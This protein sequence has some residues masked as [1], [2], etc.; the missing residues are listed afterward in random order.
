PEGDVTRR[1]AAGPGTRE[2]LGVA[3][4]AGHLDRGRLVAVPISNPLHHARD[5]SLP[6]SPGRLGAPPVSGQGE[7][8]QLRDTGNGSA[9]SPLATLMMKPFHELCRSRCKETLISLRFGR[10]FSIWKSETPHVVS[11]Q[12]H[13]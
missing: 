10:R 9:R 4:A 7:R 6:G 12:F 5:L 1:V 13:G 8:T 3:P 11:Y 2:R